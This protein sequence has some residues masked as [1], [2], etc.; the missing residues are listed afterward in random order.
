L[1]APRRDPVELPAPRRDPVE[2]PAPRRDPVELPAP[3]HGQLDRIEWGHI[4]TV[5]TDATTNPARP[6]DTGAQSNHIQTVSG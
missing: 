6:S 3:R 1:P 2:L 4:R 5:V